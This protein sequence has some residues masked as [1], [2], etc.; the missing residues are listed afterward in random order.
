MTVFDC[1]EDMAKFHDAEI[2]L[3]GK[4]RTE[5]RERRNTG[6]RRLEI[7]L[8]EEEHSQPEDTCTQGSYAMHTMVQDADCD[9]DIDDGIYFAEDDLVDEVG[10]PLTPLEAKERVSAALS[11]D[12]RFANPAE[13]FPKCVRQVYHQGYHIDMPVYR[14][15]MEDD[16]KGGEREVFELAGDGSWDASDARATT[17]WFKEKRSTLN[18]AQEGRGDQMRRVVRLTKGFARS[19]PEWKDKTSSG[20]VITKLVTDHFVPSAG[21]DDEALKKTWDAI[22]AHLNISTEVAHPVN[23]SNLAEAG[24]AKVL[25]LRDKL[26]WALKQL[27]I[28]EEECTRSEARCAWDEVFESGFFENLP[29]PTTKD[30][31]KKAFFIST[32]QKSDV[33]NDGNGRFG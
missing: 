31:A 1:G 23:A 32:S 9:Y 19:R 30:D 24:N 4:E 21:R 22:E 11:R 2:T 8:D 27:A 29:D 3:S 13:V 16:G 18:N 25:F 5:M 14:I 15:R 10:L 12:K 20:I 7:G 6:R 26:S 28:L 17:R 33:R